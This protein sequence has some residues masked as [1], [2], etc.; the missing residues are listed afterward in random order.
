MCKKR[1]TRDAC[2]AQELSVCLWLRAW[3]WRPGMESHVGL[4]AWSLRLPLP[5]SLPLSLSLSTINN[6]SLKKKKQYEELTIQTSL[7]LLLLHTVIFIIAQYPSPC[8]HSYLISNNDIPIAFKIYVSETCT[9]Y[10]RWGCPISLCSCFFFPVMCFCFSSPTYWD[11]PNFLAPSLLCNHVNHLARSFQDL[12]WSLSSLHKNRSK[13]TIQ[14]HTHLETPR[15]CSMLCMNHALFNYS[16]LTA[17]RPPFF[18]Q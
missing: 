1:K 11:L 7:V 8:L 3:S 12:P 14:H 17:I 4:P 2:V 5:V 16:L 18:L 9:C 13:S 6:K 15:Q 10:W